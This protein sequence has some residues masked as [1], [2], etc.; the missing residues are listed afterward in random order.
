PPPARRPPSAPRGR[1]GDH[2]PAWCRWIRAARERAASAALRRGACR[3]RARRPRT[4]PSPRRTGRRRGG[5]GTGRSPR[6]DER[7]RL[8]DLR[9][10]G[11]GLAGERHELLVVAH[12]LLT[13]AGQLG[14][15]RRAEERAIAIR[16]FLQRG[17]ELT[18]RRR[19]LPLLQQELGEQLAH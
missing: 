18:E 12:G 6:A 13:I 1:R 19:R 4:G 8:R 17:L 14:R 16:R 9:A 2:A 5:G 10:R 3:A 11:V 15:A 7:L